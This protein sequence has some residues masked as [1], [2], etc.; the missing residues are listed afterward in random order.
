VLFEK[1]FWTLIA[2]GSVTVTFRRWKRP[3]VV[4]G[5]PYRTPG[6]IVDVVSVRQIDPERIT[7]ADARRAGYADPESVRAALRGDPADPVLRIEFRLATGPDPRAALAASADLSA[8]ERGEIDKRLD[9][10][11]AASSY[12]PW[13]RATLDIIARRPEVR[14]GD[15][16]TD[17]G[18]ERLPFKTDVRKLKNLGLTESLPVGYRLSPRGA[19]YWQ[20]R[21]ADR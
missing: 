8:D 12:G 15:L 16:A 18:R 7:K 19:A 21:T 4:A 14:A 3:Q 1:R 11:D 10:L 5:R 20:Q 9:R 2:D 13:T 17:L 6:G